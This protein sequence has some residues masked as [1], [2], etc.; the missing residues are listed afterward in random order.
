MR[1]R[2]GKGGQRDISFILNFIHPLFG[3]VKC[4][5]AKVAH[6]SEKDRSLLILGFWPWAGKPC[7]RANHD[8]I[9]FGPGFAIRDERHGSSI[10][11][12]E[13]RMEDRLLAES[14]RLIRS[15]SV[16]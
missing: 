12:V 8:D 11:L 2:P 4:A 9:I 15:R 13:G 6:Q 5:G 16:P 14:L 10:G 1:R 3:G 7:A